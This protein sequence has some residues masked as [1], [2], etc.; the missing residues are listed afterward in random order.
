M[1]NNA[2]KLSNYNIFVDFGY[3]TIYSLFMYPK[4]GI[5]KLNCENELHSQVAP[6]VFVSKLQS[7]SCV[8]E[9]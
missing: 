2:K 3:P 5:N 7:L 9:K 1:V 6:S 8:R 4:T